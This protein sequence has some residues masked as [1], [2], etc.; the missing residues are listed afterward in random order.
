MLI[1]C[2]GDDTRIQII[3]FLI[4]RWR[5]G[6]TAGEL[7]E[8]LNLKIPTI[9]E[10]LN[11]L[12][13]SGLVRFQYRQRGGRMLKVYEL[14]DTVITLQLD[15]ELFVSIPHRTKL[16]ELAMQYFSTKRKQGLKAEFSIDDV[17]KTLGV[18]Q[19]TATVVYDFVAS[20]RD[21]FT[22]IVGM[23]ILKELKDKQEEQ[24]DQLA[25]TLKVDINWVKSAVN[26]LV[27]KGYVVLEGDKVKTVSIPESK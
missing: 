9:M 7:A 18:D 25:A 4:D 8:A 6:V 22:R 15:L 5:L 10:H 19:G 26:Y 27:N 3:K 11:L 1:D 21:E 2:L 23:D 12:E 14:V 13:E 24:V 16:E 17:A 20:R